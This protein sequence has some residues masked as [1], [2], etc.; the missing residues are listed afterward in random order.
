MS[1]NTETEDPLSV[2]YRVLL[3]NSFNFKKAPTYSSQNCIRQIT[4]L[5]EKSCTFNSRK[6]KKEDIYYSRESLTE[7][8][9]FI[10]S[11]TLTFKAP[12]TVWTVSSL[13]CD[14]IPL[15]DLAD[16][17]PAELLTGTYIYNIYVLKI[18]RENPGCQ[19]D[20]MVSGLNNDLSTLE[21]LQN[22]DFV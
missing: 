10:I 13:L 16:P 8:F 15:S 7:P 17:A 21:I 3:V 9:V 14:S 12:Y 11:L 19:V 20:S 5:T 18:R 6:P 4:F 22:G 1:E 2:L